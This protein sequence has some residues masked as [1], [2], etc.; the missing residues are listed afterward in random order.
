MDEKN[1]IVPYRTF[2]IVL[3]VLIVLTFVSVWV[4][5]IYLGP[6]TVAMAL[7][8]AGEPVAQVAFDVICT[9]I[10][11]TLVKVDDVYDPP[12]APAI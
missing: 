11:A 3:A 5:R 1:H 7:L 8:I 9:F 6:L 10:E 2:L 12:V 4:T